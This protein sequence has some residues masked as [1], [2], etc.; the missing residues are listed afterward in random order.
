MVSDSTSVATIN[1]RAKVQ[2]NLYSHLIVTFSLLPAHRIPATN[3]AHQVM[4]IC[5]RHWSV[6]DALIVC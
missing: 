1:T 4:A 3:G 2:R 5:M 6:L